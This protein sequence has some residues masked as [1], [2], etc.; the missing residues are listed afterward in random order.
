MIQ[1]ESDE[2]VFTFPERSSLLTPLEDGTITDPAERANYVHDVLGT[3]FGD[4][5][6]DG[7]F[8]SDDLISVF[9]TGIYDSPIEG[10]ATW[11]TGD[12]DGNGNFNSGDLVIAFQDGGF[13]A[14]FRPAA[15]AALS[16]VPEPGTAVLAALAL[17][18]LGVYS[19]RRR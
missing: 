8:D 10:L 9:V 15:S 6:C 14:G 12:W 1:L 11:Q 5:N 18:N 3:W 2:L 4:A 7:L 17:V 16:S 13:D 19:R